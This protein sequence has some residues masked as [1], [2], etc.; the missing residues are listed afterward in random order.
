MSEPWIAQM[1]KGLAELCILAVL[2][3]EEGYGY[4]I[5]RRLRDVE[6][7]ALTEG[8]IY[9][10]LGRMTREGLLKVRIASSQAG[11]QRR[12]YSLTAAGRQRLENMAIYWRT[13]S[14]AMEQ[15]LDTRR[16]KG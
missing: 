15:V 11:P 9:P 3:E 10:V 16:E 7:L 5:V 1:R 8:T 2:R 12:Y 13:L 14:S 4:G 6:G